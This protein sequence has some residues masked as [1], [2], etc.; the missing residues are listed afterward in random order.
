MADVSVGSLYQYFPSREALVVAVIERHRQE[1]MR[2]VRDEL[3][4][5]LSH[6][7]EQGVRSLVAAAIKAHSIDP[8]LHR[9]LAE[10]FLA[11]ASWRR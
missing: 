9:V 3:V 7:F 2:A 1:I 4:E 5:A 8:K 6:P 11:L 10:Q